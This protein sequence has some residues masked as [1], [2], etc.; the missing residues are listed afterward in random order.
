M[1]KERKKVVSL[2]TRNENA[3]QANDMKM[4]R[5]E[6]REKHGMCKLFHILHIICKH[7]RFSILGVYVCRLAH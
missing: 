3:K 2:N 6:N 7:I 4:R 1:L 5:T